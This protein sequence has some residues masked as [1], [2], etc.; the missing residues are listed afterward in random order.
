MIA[1]TIRS[2]TRVKI[3][4]FPIRPILISP[5]QWNKSAENGLRI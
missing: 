2:S 3:R 5:V 4:S 1:I